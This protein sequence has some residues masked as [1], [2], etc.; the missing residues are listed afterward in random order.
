MQRFAWLALG[1]A[2]ASNVAVAQEQASLPEGAVARLGVHRLRVAASILDMAFTPDQ[3]T[4]VVA[5]RA[6]GG[7]PPNV[8]L[9][10]VAT[11][12]ERKRLEIVEARRLAI[13]RDKPLMAVITEQF[14]EVW[15]LTA[16]KRLWQQ[17]P[18]PGAFNPQALAVSPDGTQVVAACSR[19]GKV[20]GAIILRWEARTGKTVPALYG[21]NYSIQ[22]VDFSRDGKAIVF[23]SFPRQSGPAE[24]PEIVAPGAIIAWDAKTGV[25]L[26]ET[27][28][29]HGGLVAWSPDAASIARTSRKG[30]SIEILARDGWKPIAEIAAGH[31]ACAYAPDGKQLVVQQFNE[32]LSLWDIANNKV[33]ATFEGMFW[34]YSNPPRFSNNGRLL[35]VAVDQGYANSYVQLWDLPAGRKHRFASGHPSAVK[36]LAYSPDGRRLASCSDEMLLLYDPDTGKE[37]HRWCAHK[38]SIAQITYSPDGNLLASASSD[39]T[40]ALWDPVTAKERQR[41]TTIGPVKSVAFSRD[42]KLLTTVSN[43]GAI[44]VWDL[45]V[46]NVL[47]AFDAPAKMTSSIL[48]PAG[49]ALACL[50]NPAEEGGTHAHL[51]WLSLRSGKMSAPT[52][53]RPEAL[54]SYQRSLAWDIV[55]SADSK[56]YATNDGR[57][58]HAFRTEIDDHT[59][60]LWES[61]SRREILKFRHWPTRGLAISPDNRILAHGLGNGWGEGLAS[62]TLILRDIAAGSGSKEA[63]EKIAD[64][65]QITG[66]LGWITCMAFSPDSR[67]LATGGTDKIIYLWPVKDFLKESKFAK[68]KADSASYW[69]HLADADA[70][71]AFRAIAQLEQRPKEAVALL[72]KHLQPA[73]R[74]DEK[75]AVLHFRDLSNANFAVRQQAMAALERCA[76]Q[77]AHLAEQALKNPRDLEEK[78]RL[79]L[80]L[81]KLDDPFSDPNRLRIHRSLILL[82]RIGTPEARQLLEELAQGAPAALLTTEARYSLQRVGKLQDSPK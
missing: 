54:E 50:S 43:K 27:E 22:S 5:F 14:F 11:G 78:R 30:K 56:L 73:P 70:S 39:G 59:V 37:L 66:H 7:Q 46:G 40:V 12:V 52:K 32:G 25:K 48:A 31:F 53:I 9:F 57:A 74:I 47:R 44:Q 26:S 36:G 65:P 72:R 24:K 62:R 77:V 8:I 6:I 1:Y 15:D 21:A 33:T 79:E 34:S 60:R 58:S 51:Q 2:L 41:L 67:F 3:R 76:E 55:F 4:L 17:R 19:G 42:G 35:A 16:E 82:E 28:N 81:E 61:A 38:S 29:R 63:Y 18:P 49:H 69:P 75:A 23:V 64:F 71:K 68:E 20:G 13:A 80:L 10:D 45:A